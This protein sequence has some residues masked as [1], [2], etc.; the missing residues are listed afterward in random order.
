M[1]PQIIGP[2]E[3]IWRTLIKRDIPNWQM[4]IYEPKHQ[5]NWWKVYEALSAEQKRQVEGDAENLKAAM[6]GLK[7]KK[8]N[9]QSKMV[10]QQD[11]PKLPK[12]DGMQYQHLHND[13]NR[14]YDKKK[15]RP[16]PVDRRPS[17]VRGHA[18]GLTTKTLTAKGVM[19]KARREAKEMS[20]FR[21][22]NKAPVTTLG[23]VQA[24][25]PDMI[26]KAKLAKHRCA[27]TVG[28]VGT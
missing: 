24:A 19:A 20:R 4:K 18:N 8:D 10:N 25:P 6:M 16:K 1:S 28:S 17:F 22:L 26:E 15:K 7:A 27:R 3:E 2:D 13:H 11:M 23:R 9:R 14:E 12:M 21:P 5:K